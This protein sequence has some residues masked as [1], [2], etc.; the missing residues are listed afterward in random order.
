MGVV[1]VARDSYWELGGVRGFSL[2]VG[3]YISWD[4]RGILGWCWVTGSCW[5]MS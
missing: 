5:K 3:A 1:K 2:G 4:G